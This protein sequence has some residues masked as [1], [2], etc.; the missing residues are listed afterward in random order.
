M[1]GA[2]ID[3][4]GGP[5][6]LTGIGQSGWASY[7][8]TSATPTLVQFTGV[9]DL[10]GPSQTLPFSLAM[11]TFASNGDTTDLTHTSHVGLILPSSVRYTSD[12][13][14]FL[15]ARPTEVP[16]PSSFAL[17]AS[18]SSSAVWRASNSSSAASIQASSSCSGTRAP[19]PGRFWA[20][21]WGA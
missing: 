12:S 1:V 17:Q 15:T 21:D 7:S 3:V 16:E 11:Q 14:A 4:F 13:G 19:E 8:F 5:P 2:S 18:N 10:V 20:R 6:A 9:Y